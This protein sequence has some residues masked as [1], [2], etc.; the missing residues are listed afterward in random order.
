MKMLSAECAKRLKYGL[1][2]G[3]ISFDKGDR[4]GQA[5]MYLHCLDRGLDG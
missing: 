5:E 4:N 1:K 3:Y 2:Y